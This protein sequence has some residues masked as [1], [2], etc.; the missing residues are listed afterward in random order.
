MRI[1]K[2]ELV[3]FKSFKDRTVIHF[4]AGITGVVGPN[5]CGK[6]NIVDALVWVMGEMSA[7]HLRGSSMEDVIFAGAE[8]YAPTGLAEVSLTLENDG[9]PFP[10]KYAKFSEVMVTRRLHR[11]GESEYL[12]NKE[13]ARL[14]DIQEIF[15]DTGAGSKGFSIIEQGA[16]GK[17]ITAK[18]EDRRTLIEEAAGIT[19]FKVRKR[20]SQRKLVQTDQNLVRLQDI[21]GEQKRQLDSLQR[22]AQ[23]AERYRTLKNEIRDKELW[24]MSRSYL[25]LREDLDQAQRGFIDAQDSDTS[26]TTEI[27][28][29]EADLAEMKVVVGE[30]EQVVEQFQVER[31]EIQEKSQTLEHEIRELRF[32][33]EQARRDKEM[34]GNILE[35]YQ[36][37][38]QALEKDKASYTEKVTGLTDVVQDLEQRFGE[39]NE[40]YQQVQKRITEA[41]E[42]LTSGRREM[43]TVSQSE[44][45]IE[46]K[47]LSTQTQIEEAEAKITTSREVLAELK[48]KTDE[49][50]QRHVSTHAR[51]EEERQLQ[52]GI[53]QDVENFQENLELLKVQVSEKQEEVDRFKDSLNEVSSRLYGLENLHAN[54]E[55]FEE[56]VKSVMLW[57]RERNEMHADGSQSTVVEF[58]PVAEIVEVPQEYELAM[59]A[60]LGN[61]LQMLVSDSSQTTLSAVD[62]LKEKKSGR[63]SFVSADVLPSFQENPEAGAL[64]ES[65]GFK[66]YLN[67]VVKVPDQ[68]RQQVAYF[69]KDVVVVDSIRT[70][71]HLR[72]L[73]GDKTFVT[74]EGDTLTAEGVLTGGASDSVE[75]GVLKRRREIKEL[76]QKREEWAGKLALAQGSLK[77]LEAK[78]ATV[79]EELENSKTRQ[80]EKEILVAELKKD[81][82]RAENELRNAQQALTRQDELVSREESSL[83]VLKDR[84]AEMVTTIEETREKRMNLE[85][86]VEE[87]T[88]ELKSSR[89]GIDTIQSEVTQLKV[90]SAAK[91]QELEGL[92]VQ[93][94]MVSNSLMDVTT[95]LT[96]MSEESEKSSESLS[97]NSLKIEE[98]KLELERVVQQAK[99]KDEQLGAAQNEYEELAAEETELEEKLSK[100][101]HSINEN[102]AR[103]NDAQLKL[104]QLKMKE[105]YMVDQI[106]ERYML[107]LA[108]E[109]PKY[110]DVPG[111]LQATEAEVEDLKQKIKRIGEVNLSAI[112]EYDD[113][114][115]RYQF[116]SQQ[117]QDLTEAKENLRKVID[118]INR[119]CSRRFKETFEMV[120]ERFIKVFPVLFGGGEARLI[121]V[122]DPEHNEMGIDIVAKPPGKKLQNVSLLSGGEKALTAVSLIFSIFL[123]KPSPYCL[124]DEVDAPLDDANVFRF[125]DLVG[126]MAKRSQIIVVTHNKHTMKVADKL[127]GVTMEEKG[128]SK[129]VSVN[130]HEAEKVAEA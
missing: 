88:A 78:A 77:K 101:L 36:A 44:S 54:F 97:M 47:L 110:K 72:S 115:E 11:S 51:L 122:E 107:N 95:N 17:I 65:E 79:A 10:A 127:Y 1:K 83:N 123:V 24:L 116:L 99:T 25:T 56:G 92:Q 86:K 71:L 61:R 80:I 98:Q 129:M 33:I 105:Q 29:M 38:Q 74:L 32:E 19:K 108:D 87:L 59:E 58:Q 104:E 14:R 126:E 12:I 31:K 48:T 16:I 4:D 50:Q 42:E 6:S 112:E 41:D 49:F 15:M 28:Q 82:E 113:L 106:H 118:R 3:G 27:S 60:A 18:P 121:M 2:L 85:K 8:G 75:S 22:Q 23:R 102:K 63:S 43:L 100:A 93:L 40:H 69:L 125:N 81:L 46:A 70:A 111:D 130:L 5:G 68:Y 91:R 7:K 89:E 30:K 39:R 9:G 34:T 124:L 94:E 52:L 26:V 55:G 119:I 66:S 45:H 53:M 128:V 35:Q 21:I 117:H 67:D 62:Y 114:S 13:A 90:D 37:R 103:L 76:S 120:N 64:R 73:C 96:K 84:E 109:A 57:Q 20:E